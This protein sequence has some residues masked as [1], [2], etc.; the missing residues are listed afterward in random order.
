MVGAASGDG[1]EQPHLVGSL[2]STKQTGGVKHNGMAAANMS[3]PGYR[4]LHQH[5]LVVGPASGP[6][7]ATCG[8]KGSI[9][10]LETFWCA[11]LLLAHR[12][13]TPPSH[14]S[15]DHRRPVVFV[16]CSRWGLRQ[17]LCVESHTGEGRPFAFS[18]SASSIV[19]FTLSST[20]IIP[21]TE[22]HEP[23]QIKSIKSYGSTITEV[24]EH[25]HTRPHVRLAEKTGSGLERHV[26]TGFD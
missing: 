12:A 3:S 22:A 19:S 21:H 4:A 14:D 25:E 13:P 24:K 7:R 23:Q 9:S 20:F 17:V 18:T 15:S 1:G 8:E 10:A 16:T 6:E 26:N 5:P 2:V 11:K